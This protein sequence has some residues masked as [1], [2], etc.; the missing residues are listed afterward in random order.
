MQLFV[1][2]NL[3]I[4]DLAICQDLAIHLPAANKDL[5]DNQP[6]KI[7]AYH[8]IQNSLM[9]V[10]QLFTPKLEKASVDNPQS[11]IPCKE[12]WCTRRLTLIR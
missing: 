6:M 5:E 7:F 9:I 8:M 4:V 2:V 12:A 3:R 1:F 11:P 10:G